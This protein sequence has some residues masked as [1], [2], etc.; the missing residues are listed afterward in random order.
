MQL[1]VGYTVTVERWGTPSKPRSL[2]AC[3]GDGACEGQ[4][5]SATSTGLGIREEVGRRRLAPPCDRPPPLRRPTGPRS[6]ALIPSFAP[7]GLVKLEVELRQVPLPQLLGG[8]A[9]WMVRGLR[10]R[11]RCVEGRARGSAS[12]QDVRQA[13]HPAAAS[14]RSAPSTP[15]TP[16]HPA[17]RPAT[18]R[19]CTRLTNC[20]K[21]A[22]TL[23]RR[24]RSRCSSSSSSGSC[25]ARRPPSSVWIE[26][27]TFGLWRGGARLR[28]RGS[29]DDLRA[30][31]A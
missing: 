18:A 6:A 17:R 24:S 26:S 4:V 13:G 16:P 29:G 27:I 5:R 10:V 30:T 25:S 21:S 22:L 20:R 19:T 12:V 3:G 9:G 28:G 23:L 1:T 15:P 11:G 7:E 14:R 8:G 2:H 31:P